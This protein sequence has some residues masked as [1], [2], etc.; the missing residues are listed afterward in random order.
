MAADYQKRIKRYLPI[1]IITIKP[2]KIKSLSN[3]EILKRE[4]ERIQEKLN[5]GDTVIVMDKSGKMQS[6]KQLAAAFEKM[7]LGRNR[8]LVFIIGGPLGLDEA[9]KKRA[10]QIWSFSKMTF[11]HELAA[12]M[13]LEQI[14]RVQTIRRGEKYHK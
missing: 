10:D 3:A 11:P 9:V 12:V 13:L 7:V 8:N 4:G 1:N 5:Q 14:Y 2:E 6:S